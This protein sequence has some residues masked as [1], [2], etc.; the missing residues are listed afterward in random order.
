ML[1]LIQVPPPLA[2]D[3]SVQAPIHRHLEPGRLA[4]QIPEGIIHASEAK[5]DEAGALKK[6]EVP[7]AADRKAPA[8]LLIKPQRL[9]LRIISRIN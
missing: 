4:A 3:R 8:E 7:E 6:V 9:D 2:Q 5:E 1:R